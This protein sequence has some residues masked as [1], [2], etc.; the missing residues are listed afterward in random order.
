MLFCLVLP[1]RAI[2]NSF[3]PW[4]SSE[5]YYVLPHPSM[6]PISP[7]DELC[8]FFLVELFLQPKATF[9]A[10]VC[11]F[12]HFTSFWWLPHGL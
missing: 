1:L 10:S 6:T 2:H 11:V 9:D 5:S 3:Y 8:M 7:A 4:D 12:S